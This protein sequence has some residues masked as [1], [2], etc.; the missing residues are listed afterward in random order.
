[1]CVLIRTEGVQQELTHKGEPKDGEKLV[2][3]A[4]WK[5]QM[6]LKVII[7]KNEDFG[8]ANPEKCL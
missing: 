3:K 5:Q 6:E 8:E 7:L 1:M 4:I 2:F